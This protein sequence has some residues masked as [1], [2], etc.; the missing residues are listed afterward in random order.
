MPLSNADAK[1]GRA[2]ILPNMICQRSVFHLWSLHISYGGLLLVR[3]PT[4]IIPVP[5]FSALIWMQ[6]L[7]IAE[8][9]VMVLSMGNDEVL[10]GLV[11]PN[12]PALLITL[13]NASRSPPET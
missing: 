5:A 4:F 1:S 6:L 3:W 7:T 12:V 13:M 9:M 2:D 11:A 8:N 10:C